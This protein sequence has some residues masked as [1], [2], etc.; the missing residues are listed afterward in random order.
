MSA[1]RLSDACSGTSFTKG[2]SDCAGME[3]VDVDEPSWPYGRFLCA[4]PCHCT[5]AT[6][7]R[8][9]RPVGQES[10]TTEQFASP[11]PAPPMPGWA[12]QETGE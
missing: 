11:A 3:R 4:C 1:P 12:F 6:A 9:Y 8:P 10:S 5:H 2:H 7:P